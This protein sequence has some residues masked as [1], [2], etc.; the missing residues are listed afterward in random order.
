MAQKRRALARL[1]AEYE[2]KARLKRGEAARIRRQLEEPRQV[3]TGSYE[4]RTLTLKTE[5]DQSCVLAKAKPGDFLTWGGW[6]ERLAESHDTWVINRLE[7]VNEEVKA[8]SA[9]QS[10]AP[11]APVPPIQRKP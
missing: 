5:N 9:A 3:I 2:T 8:I 7:I 10:A 1:M 4:D 11:T 6:R